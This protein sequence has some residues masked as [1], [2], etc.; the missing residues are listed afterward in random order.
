MKKTLCE[1]AV[2]GLVK[3]RTGRGGDLQDEVACFYG[4]MKE[5]NQPDMSSWELIELST[6]SKGST[7]LC[8]MLGMRVALGQG[9][10]PED[11][12]HPIPQPSLDLLDDGIGLPT[13]RALIIAVFH[14]GHRGG[15]RPLLVI[16]LTHRHCE[17]GR[18]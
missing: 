13:I 4:R 6:I 14:Q 15:F 10:V 16:A 12:A 11:K 1:M 18:S 7:S 8:R 5:K 2:Y 17:P 3:M 9:K